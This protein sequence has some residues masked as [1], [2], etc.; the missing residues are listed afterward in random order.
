MT[1][2]LVVIKL[3]GSLITDKRVQNSSRDD[4]LRRLGEEVA[5]A[6]SRGAR[7][8]LTHGSGSFGHFAAARHEVDGRLNAHGAS[9]VQQAAHALHFRVMRA[10]RDGGVNAFT[11]SPGT[12]FLGGDVQTTVP[13]ERALSQ[14]LLP[15]L[16]G[17]VVMDEK[18]GC[19]VLSTEEVVI[20]L[21]RGG[22][23]IK[24]ALW[25]GVTDGVYDENG[26]VIGRID[27]AGSATFGGESDGVDVTGGMRHRVESAIQLA[28]LG[29]PSLIA[30]G[31]EQGLLGDFLD[32]KKVRGTTVSAGERC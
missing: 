22:V 1:S 31:N 24:Q 3:G 9:E 7:L 19:R 17:D 10:L 11:I 27:N 4:V 18:L 32:G 12:M 8:L 20:G 30:N 13:L 14:G 28:K 26:S 23:P 21:V 29:V 2:D 16:H 15:V 5:L 6:L 25:L